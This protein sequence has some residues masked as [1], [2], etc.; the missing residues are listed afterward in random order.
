MTYLA[1]F[2]FYVWDKVNVSSCISILPFSE[3]SQ[4]VWKTQ[5]TVICFYPRLWGQA[6]CGSCL[7]NST[8]ESHP[9]KS[10]ICNTFCIK[11]TDICL[12]G[13]RPFP[14]RTVRPCQMRRE[15]GTACPVSPLAWFKL[16]YLR[17]KGAL[18]STKN[19]CALEDPLQMLPLILRAHKLHV[20]D[21]WGDIM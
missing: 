1:T 10:V 11:A 9:A 12:Q 19:K 18:W 7:T 8:A 6:V 3:S 15:A 13:V 2:S 4:I 16:L 21:I 14:S 17:A 5:I 20:T